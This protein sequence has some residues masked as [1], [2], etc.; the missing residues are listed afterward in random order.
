MDGLLVQDIKCSAGIDVPEK[1]VGL[2]MTAAKRMLAMI[3]KKNEVRRTPRMS[4]DRLYIAHTRKIITTATSIRIS[5]LK[6]HYPTTY[7][8]LHQERGYISTDS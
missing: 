5:C 3:S 2:L 6:V 8:Q 4:I 7:N 1:F